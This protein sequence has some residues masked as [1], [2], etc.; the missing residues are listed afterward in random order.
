MAETP[1]SRG[2]AVYGRQSHG[3][4][5]S[6]E[7]QLLAGHARC[8]LLERPV[9]REYSDKV[10]VSRFGTK[11]REDWP[12]LV[13]DVEAGHL[14]LVWLWDASRGDR[15][16]E[17]WFAFLSASR[18]QRVS[19][20]SERDEYSYRPW[21]PRDWKT[22]AE[23]GV[24]AAYESEIR[25]VDVRRGIASMARKGLPHGGA[26]DGYDRIYDSKD[27]KKFQDVPNERGVIIAEIIERIAR[28]DP[29]ITIQRDLFERGIPAAKWPGVPWVVEPWPRVT[30]R[31]IGM[32]P[33]YAGL[34]EHD[35][36]LYEGNWEGVVSREKWET[37][38]AVL[39]EP[40]RKQSAPGALKY[41]LSYLMVTEHRGEELDISGDPGGPKRPAR[42][43]CLDDGCVS[44]RMDEADEHVT[45][46]V[47]ARLSHPDARQFFAVDND[48]LNQANALVA[49]IK[50]EAEELEAE[51]KSGRMRPAMA[52]VVDAAIQERLTAAQ[53]RAQTLRGS[54]SALALLDGEAFTQET[55]WPRWEALSLAARRSVI[56]L[57]IERIMLLPTDKRLTRYSTAEA[58]RR[59]AAERVQITWREPS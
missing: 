29:I 1:D 3:K 59:L 23:L 32:N 19:L 30:I 38:K 20:Y 42:Y 34:R 25:S 27:R 7:D 28:R 57:L 55:A 2:A 8:A 14:G 45:R 56:N 17:S 44:I 18:N 12:K 39:T 36:Q 58:R 11:E 13:A 46:V 9:V 22:L 24:D 41:L 21:I 48:E 52:A 6:V 5:T 40:T 37:A 54:A 31:A 50:A 43:R 4:E 16:P 35:G 49:S 15:T 26:R 10:S 51:I 33:Y 47:L 53:L